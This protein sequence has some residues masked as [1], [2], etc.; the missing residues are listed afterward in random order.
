MGLQIGK[1]GLSAADRIDF[2]KTLSGW[3]NS[4]GGRMSVAEAVTNT[5]DAFSHDEYISLRPKMDAIKREVQGAQIQMYEAL[6]MSGLGFQPQEL[7][8]IEAA[9]KSSQLRQ[10]IPSLV[11]ALEIQHNGQRQMKSQLMGP[12]VIGVM[13]IMMS[14]GVI[15]F[16]LPMVIQPVIDRNPNALAKFPS[17]LK[18][19]WYTSVWLRGN[20]WFPTSLVVVPLII[21]FA[22]NT[23][24]LKPTMQRIMLGWGVSRKLI[25]G[26]NGVVTVFFM[27]ALLR[28]GLPTYRVLQYVA[29]CVK[30]PTIS[31]IFRIASQEHEEGM[32]MSQA[33][34][35]VPFR[36]SF[37]NA[38]RAGESTGAIAD[39][40][41]DLQEPYTIELE[42]NI[43]NV[44]AT[45]KF[46]VMGILL[47]FFIVS[48]YTALVGP[49][50]ALMEY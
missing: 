50:F 16:M 22:R 44:V 20:P 23:P 2:F 8:I 5:C 30:N 12:L 35:T 42:R 29:D 11:K 27:P 1:A 26:F 14:M 47:P 41:E 36:A 4:G 46:L 6:R 31:N 15:Y 48:T 49:I 25:L 10:A 32:R 40:V 33:L 18:Y 45:L 21:Y 13:L 7:S 9:E 43:K 38:I 3:L 39:R 24:L 19:Y 34:E 37:V 28:S 17:I